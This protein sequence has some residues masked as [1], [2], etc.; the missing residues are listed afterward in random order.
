MADGLA[1]VRSSLAGIADALAAHL[2]A[3]YA[4]E[5]PAPAEDLATLLAR[6]AIFTERAWLSPPTMTRP[7]AWPTCSG[8]AYLIA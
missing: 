6:A 2:P 7:P 4:P 3:R 8:S 1:A 5:T